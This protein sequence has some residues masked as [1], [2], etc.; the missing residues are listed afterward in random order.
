MLEDAALFGMSS[1]D[2]LPM[3]TLWD[4]LSEY[5]KEQVLASDREALLEIRD[6]LQNKINIINEFLAGEKK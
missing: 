5:D 3:V 4:N 6:T 1:Q 2:E